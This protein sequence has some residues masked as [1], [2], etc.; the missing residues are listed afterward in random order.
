MAGELERQMLAALVRVLVYSKNAETARH[1]AL[2]TM[3]SGHGRGGRVAEVTVAMMRPTLRSA[4]RAASAIS[5]VLGDG[6]S[7]GRAGGHRALKP[8]ST[9]TTLP[10]L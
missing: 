1:A 6:S 3:N 8:P 4:S 7:P 9:V 5:V 2:R 10:V